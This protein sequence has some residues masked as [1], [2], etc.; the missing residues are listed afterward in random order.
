MNDTP[1]GRLCCKRPDKTVRHRGEE[2]MNLTKR[3]RLLSAAL[4]TLL[5]MSG[6]A[7]AA[8]LQGVTDTEI[9]IGTTADLSGVTA[10][11]GVNNANSL[12]MVFDQANAGGGI[13][14]RKIHYVVEDMGSVAQS[15][16]YHGIGMVSR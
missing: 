1:E 2:D 15:G 7:Y 11:Q 16:S 3:W 13:N 5:A 6:V 8:E 4:S 10:V 9:V 12:R 14:G